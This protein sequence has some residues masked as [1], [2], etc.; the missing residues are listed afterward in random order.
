MEAR[1]GT[2]QGA[3]GQDLATLV[4]WNSGLLDKEEEGIND[5]G[6]TA[7]VE[8]VEWVMSQVLGWK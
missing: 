2:S 8:D 1:E 6:W 4:W 5:P 7:A 3:S